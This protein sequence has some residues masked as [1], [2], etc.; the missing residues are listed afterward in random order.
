MA[1]P[2][3]AFRC[4]KVLSIPLYT[5]YVFALAIYCCLNDLVVRNLCVCGVPVKKPFKPP[6]VKYS[7][8]CAFVKG[9]AIIWA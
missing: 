4:P 7:C 9:R 5:M 3:P 8:A 1:V 6:F 2:R